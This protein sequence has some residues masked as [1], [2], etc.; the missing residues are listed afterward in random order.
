VGV[1]LSVA[2]AALLRDFLD[3]IDGAHT[4]CFLVGA[5][6]RVLT[7]DERWRLR[8]ARTTLDWDFAIRA[9]SWEHWSTLTARLLKAVPPKFRAGVAEHRFIHIDGGALDLVPYG[10]LESPSGEIL[11]PS[12]S[13]MSVLGFKESEAGCELV[14][15]GMDLLVPVAAIPSLALLKLHAYRDRR[16]RG[17]SKDIQDFDWFLRHYESAGNELR[18][19]EELGDLLRAEH[20][21]IE[22]AG[23]A[24]LG[25]D[26]AWLHQPMRSSRRESC[27]SR[28]AI[29]GR[30]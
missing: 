6:A 8:G 25:A 1:T 5:G 3:A 10:G 11:W 16:K 9:A 19:H 28:R 7:F 2:D 4:T 22:N 17:E 15:I 14:D 23:A 27:W 21:S 24:L 30:V 18:V 12:K 29:L 26:V 13:R 20:L